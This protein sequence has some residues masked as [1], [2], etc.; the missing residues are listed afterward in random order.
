M[1]FLILSHNGILPSEDT[2]YRTKQCV[3]INEIKTFNIS[4]C[5]FGRYRVTPEVQKCFLFLQ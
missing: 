2:I 3:D 5:V 1:H 4:F